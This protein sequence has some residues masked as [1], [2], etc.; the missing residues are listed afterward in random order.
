MKVAVKYFIDEPSRDA[1]TA[2]SRHFFGRGCGS[3]FIYLGCEPRGYGAPLAADVEG[4]IV[5]GAV[6]TLKTVGVF[7]IV[8]GGTGEGEALMGKSILELLDLGVFVEIVLFHFAV[9]VLCYGCL[10]LMSLNV[11]PLHVE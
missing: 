1:G 9:L 3:L 2:D 6:E 4:E 11:W 7:I 5:D 10:V 8:E